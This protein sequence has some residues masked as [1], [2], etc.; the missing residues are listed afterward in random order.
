MPEAKNRK[1]NDLNIKHMLHHVFF[2][3]RP[4]HLKRVPGL[5]RQSF[6]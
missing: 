4:W 6:T 2:F 3:P 1:V 5:P